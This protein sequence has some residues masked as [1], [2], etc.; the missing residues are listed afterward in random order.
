MTRLIY[1]LGLAL[2][3]A[4]C[5]EDPCA[6]YVD[7]MCSCH[8]GDG[9]QS[10]SDLHTTLSDADPALQDECALLLQAQKQDDQANGEVCE[11]DTGTPGGVDSGV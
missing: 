1:P 6:E 2:S 8:E 10:C 4:G 9:A 11:G 3:L 7:Y 5:I